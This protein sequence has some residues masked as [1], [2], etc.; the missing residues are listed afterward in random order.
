MHR[1]R[2]SLHLDGKPNLRVALFDG[3]SLGS[4]RTVDCLDGA[5]MELCLEC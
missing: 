1:I 5:R 3:A 2:N 4:S